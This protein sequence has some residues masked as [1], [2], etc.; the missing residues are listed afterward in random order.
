MLLFPGVG[1]NYP[2]LDEF[3]WADSLQAETVEV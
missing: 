1:R 3:R 2:K